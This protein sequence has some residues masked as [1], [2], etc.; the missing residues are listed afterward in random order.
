MHLQRQRQRS[1][2]TPLQASAAIEALAVF[3]RVD[4]LPVQPQVVLETGTVKEPLQPRLIGRS[5]A[6][7]SR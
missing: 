3:G 2:E 7:L 4:T 1:G 6:S 5:K